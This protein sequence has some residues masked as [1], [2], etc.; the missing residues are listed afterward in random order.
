MAE[1]TAVVTSDATKNMFLEC[2]SGIRAGLKD[3]SLKQDIIKFDGT[4]YQLWSY[5][6]KT[7]LT[8]VGYWGVVSGATPKPHWPL[9][10]RPAAELQ[11]LTSFERHIIAATE[12]MIESRMEALT[13]EEEIQLELENIHHH[14]DVIDL[15]A[16][17]VISSAVNYKYLQLLTRCETSADCWQ[18]LKSKFL[19]TSLPNQIRL[20]QELQMVRLTQGMTVV[21][22]GMRL[23][24]LRDK[25]GNVGKTLDE[26]TM[27][28]HLLRGL[29]QEF[30]AVQANIF[31]NP[32]I[33]Y[34]LAYN[35]II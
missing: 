20:E 17:A 4:N 24:N 35:Q 28:G 34:E 26:S 13:T 31:A 25:L 27:L 21:Q 12:K 5:Q 8:T 29:P 3:I 11:L 33:T 18:R 30:S 6:V 14:W 9:I 10:C 2:Q 7:S 15:N 23:E 22:Y 16:K 19:E 1:T 32:Q